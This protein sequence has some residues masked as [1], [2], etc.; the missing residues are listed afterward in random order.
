MGHSMSFGFSHS[1]DSMDRCLG[2]IPNNNKSIEVQMMKQFMSDQSISDIPQPHDFQTEF[3]EFLED[4][5]ELVGSVGSTLNSSPVWPSVGSTNSSNHDWSLNAINDLI[6]LPDHCTRGIFGSAEVL[7]L[8]KL[9]SVMYSVDSSDLEAPSS[10]HEY[11]HCCICSRVLGS[12]MSRS[13]ASSIAMT[14]WD[15]EYFGPSPGNS[16]S[17][18]GQEHRPARIN[19]FAKYA[20]KIRGELSLHLLVSIC[21][22]KHHP[23]KDN[24]G[25]PLSVWECDL[26]EMPGVHSVVPIQFVHNR[27]VSL[28]DRISDSDPPLLFVIPCVEL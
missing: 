24:Y 19:F 16:T 6:T 7:N 14:I 23:L 28:V 17:A 9:F 11:S 20:I 4:P 27:A 8:V 1:N 18:S 22:Y 21:W 12:Y 25:K 3:A 5:T 15:S 13:S 2:H 26:Y 10:F